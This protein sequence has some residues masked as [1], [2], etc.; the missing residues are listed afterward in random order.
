MM[1]ILSRCFFWSVSWV[2]QDSKI[3][4]GNSKWIK[5]EINTYQN[6]IVIW[7]LI[8]Y[9]ND[10]WIEWTESSIWDWQKKS[11]GII[12]YL[13]VKIDGLPIPKGR[14]VQGPTINQY[15]GTT[16]PSTFQGSCNYHG[17]T[18]PETNMIPESPGRLED[19]HILLGPG[20]I[21]HLDNVLPFPG[22]NKP[23]GAPWRDLPHSHSLAVATSDTRSRP[24]IIRVNHGFFEK[25]ISNWMYRIPSWERSHISLFKVLLK[26]MFIFPRWDMWSFPGECGFLHF[27]VLY[28]KSHNSTCMKP[29]LYLHC[30]YTKL[31][32]LIQIVGKLQSQMDWHK[33]QTACQ[34]FYFG[35]PKSWGLYTVGFCILWST[36]WWFQPIT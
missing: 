5:N 29:H 28:T 18:L 33:S 30:T 24:F 27:S 8:R 2:G 34:G 19:F 21:I 13:K 3:E 4:A 9:I 17:I 14:L 10:S 1:P 11:H 23:S 15:A 7:M 26:I 16:M 35:L 6:K 20:P 12:G 32:K 36:G 25:Q 31:A 22:K